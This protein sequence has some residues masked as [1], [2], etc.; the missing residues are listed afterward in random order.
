[1][2]AAYHLHYAKRVFKRILNAKILERSIMFKI[3]VIAMDLNIE[4]ED[5]I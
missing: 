4:Y 1:M 3:K 2:F 5:V